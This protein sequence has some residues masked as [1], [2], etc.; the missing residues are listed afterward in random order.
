MQ[1]ADFEKLYNAVASNDT[2]YDGVFF[3]AVKTTGIFCRP[4]CKSKL[5]KKENI[6]FYSTAKEAQAQ[7]YRAC[8]RCRSDLPGYQPLKEIAAKLKT[9]ID[10]AN[11]DILELNSRIDKQGLSKKRMVEVFK[12]EY[13]VTPTEYINGLRFEKA[14][15]LLRCTDD[16]V[17]DI[18]YEIGFDSLSA[19]Y[20]FFKKRANVSPLA[21][22]KEGCV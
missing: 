16:D 2:K 15:Q 19:F 12:E 13:G 6:E 20:S 11:N 8:K 4:S 3:Y 1:N 9:L 14:K 22:R 10:E 18:A 7:G 17:I 21:Y 5:P